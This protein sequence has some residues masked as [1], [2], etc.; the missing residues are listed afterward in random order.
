MK[1]LLLLPAALALGGCAVTTE[2][3]LTEPLKEKGVSD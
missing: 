1:A 3:T 2:G